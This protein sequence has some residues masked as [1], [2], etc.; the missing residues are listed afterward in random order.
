MYCRDNHYVNDL[1]IFQ[2]GTYFQVFSQLFQAAILVLF[3]C[4]THPLP[5]NT[6]ME[7]WLL[8]RHLLAPLWH[9]L[10]TVPCHNLDCPDPDG[11]SQSAKQSLTIRSLQC[12][13]CV[14]A[15]KMTDTSVKR[16]KITF[17][18]SLKQLTLSKMRLV[19]QLIIR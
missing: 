6:H 18:R 12:H 8:G 9:C 17:W 15:D 5:T 7:T 1:Y 14:G 4:P 16:S 3:Y 11:S 13:L 2:H 19:T 10:Q